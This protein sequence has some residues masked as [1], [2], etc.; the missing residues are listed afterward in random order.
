MGTERKRSNRPLVMSVF[1]P[2]PVYTVM[3]T[4]AC[5][6][7]PGRRNWMYSFGDPASAP[8]NRNVNIN[9]I[10]SGN[11]VT[12]KSWKGTCLILSSARQPSVMDAESALAARGRGVVARMVFAVYAGLV[13][14]VPP[15]RRAPRCVR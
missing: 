11:T 15:R 2:T 7:M 13:I 6:M 8:P 4:I 14:A 10:I 3:N 1:N 9:V 12:S 5:T